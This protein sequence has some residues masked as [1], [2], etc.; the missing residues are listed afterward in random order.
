MKLLFENWRQYIEEAA[1]YRKNK[2]TLYHIGPR[3][4]EPKPATRHAYRGYESGLFMTNN[5]IGIAKNHGIY[6]NVYAYKVPEWAITKAGGLN[7]Y[8]YGSEIIFPEDIWNEAKGEIEFL[9]KSMS[10]QELTKKT[11]L[12][13]A[14]DIGLR[15]SRKQPDTGEPRK[16]GWV[17]DEEWEPL[18][19]EKD[20]S[21]HL[22]LR[23]AAY[24]EDAI[25]LMTPEE[26]Q[27]ALE[28]FEREFERKAKTLSGI[29]LPGE[30]WPISK[31]DQE[32]VTL[33]KK[34]IEGS[35]YSE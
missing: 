19:R 33:L 18:Q 35:Q 6:G 9:G 21:K 17:S 28:A 25:K 5:P 26:R 4:A 16:P 30:Q 32:I 10:E 31:R 8:D 2:R 34:Y 22:K 14:W 3:P 7:R 27:K 15:R 12:G 20:T 13:G 29:L 24:L 1:D 23:Q 11:G